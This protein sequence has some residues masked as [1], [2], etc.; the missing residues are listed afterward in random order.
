MKDVIERHELS[1]GRRVW[2]QRTKIPGV[3][4]PVWSVVTTANYP[5]EAPEI[6]D[7]EDKGHAYGVLAGILEAD[8]ME[9][10]P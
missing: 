7:A 6:V 1:D 10:E 8:V 3:R 5:L 4:R 2:I 9:R